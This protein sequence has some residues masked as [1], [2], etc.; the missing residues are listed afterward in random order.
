MNKIIDWFRRNNF[1]ICW[2]LIGF[3]VADGLNN[4]GRGN[5]LGA[6]LA[7]ALAFVNYF[8]NRR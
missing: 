8:F 6:L 5:Y 7:F 1:E 2:F 3:L 4:L